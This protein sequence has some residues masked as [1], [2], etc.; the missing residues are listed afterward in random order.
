MIFAPEVPGK[1]SLIVKLAVAD[2]TLKS[3]STSR[4][5]IKKTASGLMIS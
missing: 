1:M 4:Y 2:D 5:A 3:L